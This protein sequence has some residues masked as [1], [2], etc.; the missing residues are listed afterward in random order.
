ML[1]MPF[2]FAST[3]IDPPSHFHASNEP[4]VP[5][6]A[7]RLSGASHRSAGIQPA[8]AEPCVRGPGAGPGRHEYR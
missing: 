4:V 3:P 5:D 2:G 8:R 6:N 1:L 7:L